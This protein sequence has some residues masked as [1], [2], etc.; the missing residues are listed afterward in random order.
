MLFIYCLFIDDIVTRKIR[1]FDD[2][3]LTFNIL[4]TI[5]S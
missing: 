1:I 5:Y 3:I 2:F 4:N